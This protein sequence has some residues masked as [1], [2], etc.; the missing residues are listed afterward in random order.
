M[1]SLYHPGA[2]EA[3]HFPLKTTHCPFS[4]TMETG[5]KAAIP[6]ILVSGHGQAVQPLEDSISIGMALLLQ[7]AH[8]ISKSAKGRGVMEKDTYSEWAVIFVNFQEGLLSFIACFS[9]RRTQ[10]HEQGS[11]I[12]V[13]CPR[14]QYK[15]K[16]KQRPH[17]I[18]KRLSTDLLT[19]MKT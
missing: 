3:I 11:P 1:P 14:P 17:S 5:S 13:P 12:G 7:A 9:S 15:Y 8:V 18:V 6:A 10:V 2:S 4:D 19:I 16:H